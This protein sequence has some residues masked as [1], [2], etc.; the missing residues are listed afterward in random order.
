MNALGAR[1]DPPVV[2]VG[3]DVVHPPPTG[4]DHAGIAARIP[5]AGRMCLLDRLEAWSDTRIRCSATSHADAGNPLRS[6]SGL[7]APCAIEYAAQAMALHGALLATP[8][9]QPSPGYL[10]SVRSVQCHV[11]RLDDVDGALQ[12]EAE[13][14]AGD[15][16]QLLYRFSVDDERGKVLVEGRAAVVLNAP[17][18][19]MG[20]GG[21]P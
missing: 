16:G 15:G 8:A 13:R 2:V 19:V 9:T 5:H 10:V 20:E 6:A 17:L 12:I 1:D 18:A 4:L 3:S 14:L 11:L 21:A 7:L